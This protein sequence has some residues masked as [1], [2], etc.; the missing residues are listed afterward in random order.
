[1]ESRAAGTRPSPPPDFLS[2]PTGRLSSQLS[3][4]VDPDP[5]PVPDQ[6]SDD[7]PKCRE[8]K[9]IGFEPLFGK[10]GS[11]HTPLTSSRLFICTTGRLSSQLRD[12]FSI[13]FRFQKGKCGPHKRKKS[14]R[15]FQEFLRDE[16]FPYRTGGVTQSLEVHKNLKFF[17]T[18][19]RILPS[20]AKKQKPLFSTF[21]GLLHGLLSF[22]TDGNEHTVSN[23]HLCEE[24][25]KVNDEKSR[26]KGSGSVIQ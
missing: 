6:F 8:F 1:M 22:K 12:F 11:R 2:V 10:H 21:L 20:L 16:C 3:S 5:E 17:V 23:K 26:I 15:H 25:L 13:R 18:Q 4:V 7:K 14:L 9:P 24:I 19:I